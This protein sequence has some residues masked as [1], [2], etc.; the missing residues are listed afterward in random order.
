MQQAIQSMVEPVR[1]LANTSFKPD[2]LE[3]KKP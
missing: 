1:W 3:G 2:W